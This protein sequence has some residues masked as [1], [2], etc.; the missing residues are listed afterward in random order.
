[1][2]TKLTKLLHS[3]PMILNTLNHNHHDI[4]SFTAYVMRLFTQLLLAIVNSIV[5]LLQN[6]QTISE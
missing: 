4:N 6:I 5:I 3:I 2:N 1:M